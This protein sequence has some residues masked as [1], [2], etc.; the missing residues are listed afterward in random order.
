MVA[1]EGT[2]V[3][4]FDAEVVND[5]EAGVGRLGRGQRARPRGDQSTEAVDGGGF[6]LALVPGR[7]DAGGDGKHEDALVGQAGVVLCHGEVDGGLGDGVGG[8]GVDLAGVDE[9]GVG[10][11]FVNR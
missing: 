1:D 9:V 2:S 7:H 3:A 8:A 10:H 5:L 6:P 4:L 11:L